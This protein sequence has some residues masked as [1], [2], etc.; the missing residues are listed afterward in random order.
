MDAQLD[1]RSAELLAK[2]WRNLWFHTCGS[3]GWGN[4]IFNSEAECR[5]A[6]VGFLSEILRILKKD[7]HHLIA[8]AN[9]ILPAATLSYAIP[10]PIV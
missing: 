4:Y 5:A 7:R 6:Q 8:H 3:T 9:C 1:T 2:Q 10:M